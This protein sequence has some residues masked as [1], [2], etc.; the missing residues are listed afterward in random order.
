MEKIVAD[1]KLE[2]LLKDL[3]DI[4][5]KEFKIKT[6]RQKIEQ[7]IYRLTGVNPAEKFETV[8]I[9]ASFGKVNVLSTQSKDIS[10]TVLAKFV[11]IKKFW[12]KLPLKDSYPQ[13][14]F[15]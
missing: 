13:I 4:K 10:K 14:Q 6:E 5:E 7:E 9:E 11:D 15:K 2:H 1:K 3:K 8:K 12:N